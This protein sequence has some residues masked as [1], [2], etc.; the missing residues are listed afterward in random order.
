MVKVL[1]KKLAPATLRAKVL[2]D[3][4]SKNVFVNIDGKSHSVLVDLSRT[5]LFDLLAELTI[6]GLVRPGADGWFKASG[7]KINEQRFL[8][9][10]GI[11]NDSTIFFFPRGRGGYP[12]PPGSEGRR[13]SL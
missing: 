1:L 4:E 12:Y 8:T 6:L 9:N 7:R 3:K 13:S 11:D 2:D 10:C 5:T